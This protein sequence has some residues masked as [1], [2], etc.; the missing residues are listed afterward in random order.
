MLTVWNIKKAMLVYADCKK[1]CTSSFDKV[2][3]LMGLSFN[4]SNSFNFSSKAVR[5]I[6][7]R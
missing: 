4:R 6:F 5:S 3:E 1:R 2:S 7:I